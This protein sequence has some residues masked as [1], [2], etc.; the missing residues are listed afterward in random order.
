MEPRKAELK[1]TPEQLRE[2]SKSRFQIVK[3][4]ERIAPRPGGYH[5]HYP[6]WYR[7]GPPYPPG[8]TK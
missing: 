8:H 1:K 6:G 5:Y 3:L 7:Q 2:A 4:E